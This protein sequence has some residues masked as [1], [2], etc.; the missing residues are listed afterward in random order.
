MPKR[1]RKESAL[2]RHLEILK[3]EAGCWPGYLHGTDAK[4][5][6]WEL[7]YDPPVWEYQWD[8]TL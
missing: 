8:A 1:Y 2:L 5:D 3:R 4:G 6:Y 7:L